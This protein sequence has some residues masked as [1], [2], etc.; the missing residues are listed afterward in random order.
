MTSDRESIQKPQDCSACWEALVTAA[1]DGEPMPPSAA[2]HLD[3]CPA[4]RSSAASVQRLG[5]AMSRLADRID[6]EASS[7]HTGLPG[8]DRIDLLIRLA[9]YE[10]WNRRARRACA[11]SV[12]IAAC[13]AILV[14]MFAGTDAERLR[15]GGDLQ[16]AAV[17]PAA[18]RASAGSAGATTTDEMDDLIGATMASALTV[19][20]WAD[21][22][23]KP[24]AAD[25]SVWWVVLNYGGRQQHGRIE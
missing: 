4:C 8:R 19:H 12:G 3:V 20:G 2:E 16:M 9:R 6:A 5:G 11:A 21:R 1:R 14:S 25:S 10:A 22:P 17:Q 13:V 18:D 23:S 7:R 24:T 15:P